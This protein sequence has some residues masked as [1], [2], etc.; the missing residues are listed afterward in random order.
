MFTTKVDNLFNIIE[1][2]QKVKLLTVAKELD[3]PVQSATKIARYFEQ[4]GLVQLDYKN[5]KGPL[6]IFKKSPTHEFKQA[7]ESELIN[8]LKFFKSFNNIEAANKLIYDYY[9]YFKSREDEESK[10]V[11]V[12]LR[13][14]YAKNFIK[15]F[16]G[17]KNDNPIEKLESYSVQ[18]EKLLVEIDVI[19]QVLEPVPFYVVSLLKISDITKL[20][21]NSIMEEVISTI[22]FN[23]VFKTHDEERIV[24]QQYK[25]KILEIMHE[26]FP[27]L[28]DEKLHMFSD[29]IIMTSLGMGEVEFLLR[30]KHLEE[31]VINNAFEPIWVYHK[32]YGWLETNVVIDD[33]DKIVHYATLAG[34]NVDKNITTLSPLLDASLASGDRVNATLNPITTKGN[35]ITIRKFAESPWSIIDFLQNNTIDYYSAAM[36]W[37][38]MQYELSILFVGGTGSG[39]TS[40]LNVFSIF[41]PPN[42]RVISIEDTRELRLP[43]T[44]HWVPMETRLA[45]PEGKGEVSMLDLIVNSLRMRPDRI[46][47]GEIRRKKEAEVLFEAMHTG[48][49]VY[50]TLHANTAHEAVT[51]LTS[52]PFSIPKS[53]MSAVDLIYVQNRNRGTNKRRV[54]QLAEVNDDGVEN[55]IFN[56]NFSKDALVKAQ[57]PDAFYKRLQIFAGLTKAQVEKEIQD[58]IKILKHLVKNNIRSNDDIALIVN[59]YYVDRR[60][61]DKKLFG[62]K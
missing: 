43:P 16:T 17:A 12:S 37:T 11:Y 42:Q 47:V 48:H 28:E 10:K 54:F 58:K 18:A 55:V 19:K 40:S 61:L 14:Y 31:I 57:A 33:E 3:L 15:K 44:L 23:A 20:I 30:D 26:V 13:D 27:D 60:Y 1:E 36:I 53:L 34:R 2:R 62:G 41:I 39:K 45:N 35:T 24:K 4:N 8:K 49:S 50:A 22:T 52:D 21:I 9:Q 7:S 25:E 38:A 51:R 59:Y 6:V 29:Y 56:Y 32:K 46:L 5:I